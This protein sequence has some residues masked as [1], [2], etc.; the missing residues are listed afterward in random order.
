MICMYIVYNI[1]GDDG[2]YKN[3]LTVKGLYLNMETRNLNRVANNPVNKSWIKMDKQSMS[4]TNDYNGK[5]SRNSKKK[6]MGIK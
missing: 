1:D 4:I 5:V 3:R 2:M 6:M